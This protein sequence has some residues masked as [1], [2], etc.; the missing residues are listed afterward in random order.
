MVAM[1]GMFISGDAIFSSLAVG[2]ILVVA[3]AVL[4]SLTVLPALLALL[5]DK[6]DRPR[7]PL[8]H[9]LRRA[10]GR[11]RV[12]PVV[13]RP[14]LARPWVAFVVAAGALLALAIPATQ[15]RT[16][17]PGAEDLPRSIPIMQSYDRL[18]AAFPETGDSHTVVIA[19]ENGS[20]LPKAQVE[21]ATSD[22]I[23]A[24]KATGLFALNETPEPEFS[25]DGRV[26]Q[27]E[28]PIPYSSDSAKAEQSLEDLRQSIVPHTL[29]TI[30]NATYGVTGSTAG[31]V[32]FSN[33]QSSR[34]PWV[35]AFV[36]GLTFVVMLVSFRSVVIAVTAIA[37]N[38]LSVGA[39][40]GLLV[41]VFQGHWAEGLLGFHSNSAIVAWLPL[42][43]FVVLFG[44]SMDY[45]VF[46]VSRIREAVRRG[47][48]TRE[49]V[50]EGITATAGTVTSAAIV[51]VAVF[52][53]FATLSTLDFKQLGIGLAAAIL[54]DATIVRAV[55][56]PATM[57]VL[58]RANWWAPRWM[59]P[60][61]EV[62]PVVARPVEVGAGT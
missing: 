15:L 41:L 42:F 9:R 51:M 32:D 50:A 29:G 21:R 11:S 26:A 8:L 6:I 10:D 43:L 31:T 14:V 47:V 7:V 17:F 4:G 45:H 24:A 22:M 13:L 39:A 57:A 23:R 1:A 35:F 40:Y 16:S 34:M 46:V 30:N 37:L 33:H 55:L 5:G 19:S 58:G 2:C 3:V 28:L 53:I 25:T 49:A 38:L 52:S 27:V 18:T 44:L 36:L 20:P 54:I 48:P 60:A 59:R 61:A 62:R 12:W 56:L